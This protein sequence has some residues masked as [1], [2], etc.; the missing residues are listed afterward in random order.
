MMQVSITA[1]H[2]D[3]TE[4]LREHTTERI[5]RLSKYGVSLLEAHAVLAVEKYRHKAE[6]TLHGNG[7]HLTGASESDDMYTSVDMVAQKL[8][9]QVRRQ[10]EKMRSRK[11]APDKESVRFDVVSSGSVGK[12]SESIEIVHSSE[13]EAPPMSVEDAIIR[14]EA[15]DEDYLFFTNPISERVNVLLKRKDGNYGVV[16]V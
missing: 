6:V 13:M 11:H 14:L 7:F 5:G 16:E 9:V 4:G 2:F 12:G 8:E 1:R 10:K 3:L 15:T